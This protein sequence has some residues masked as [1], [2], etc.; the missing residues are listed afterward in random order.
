MADKGAANA[1]GKPLKQLSICGF[2][3]KVPFDSMSVKSEPGS[4]SGGPESEG[5]G[6]GGE[7]KGK[8]SKS[9][10]VKRKS[11]NKQGK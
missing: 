3:S 9:S 7:G 4:A 8:G 6:K 5:M 10:G 2:V 1:D 11:K